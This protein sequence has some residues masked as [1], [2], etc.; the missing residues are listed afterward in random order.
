MKSHRAQDHD[1][2]P[3]AAAVQQKEADALK[4]GA[5]L[6]N[7]V[8]HRNFHEII[9]GSPY[10]TAQ[11]KRLQGISG[12][13][14]QKQS[15]E[16]N[17]TGMPD[18]LKTKMETSFDTDFSDVRVH[19]NSPKAPEVGASAYTQGSDIH[20]APGQFTPDTSGGQSL[21]GHELAH[22]V[23]QRDN[24]VQPTTEVAGLPVNDSPLLED[25]ADAMGKNIK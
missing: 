2:S 8:V 21:L 6:S 1:R 4:T 13:P 16:P 23:Q 10:M 14:A 18:E 19:S 22:V 12:Q 11:R 9:D 17:R 24:R 20:F 25:E 15:A 5:A 7:R 3:R